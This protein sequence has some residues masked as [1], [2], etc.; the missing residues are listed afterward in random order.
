MSAQSWPSRRSLRP[1]WRRHRS[2]R[3]ASGGRG[4]GEWQQLPQL[5]FVGVA[6]VAVVATGSIVAK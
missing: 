6:L 4:V 1:R 5:Y 3:V 2:S